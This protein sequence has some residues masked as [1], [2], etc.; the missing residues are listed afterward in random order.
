MVLSR[1][2]KQSFFSWV[3]KHLLLDRAELRG[4]D[5]VSK[6]DALNAVTILKKYKTNVH[7]F[8]DGIVDFWPLPKRVMERYH[9]DD[10]DQLNEWLDD[11]Y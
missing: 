9:I 3:K 4:H 6:Q 1:Q 7:D 8:T 2:A 11:I 10:V 5:D